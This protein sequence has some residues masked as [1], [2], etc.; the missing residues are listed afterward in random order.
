MKLI[1]HAVPSRCDKE[2]ATYRSV[3]KGIP[4]RSPRYP[5]RPL[6]ESIREIEILNSA[7]SW[8]VYV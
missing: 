6:R 5:L 4:L 7:L 3:K 2:R 8:F 1:I